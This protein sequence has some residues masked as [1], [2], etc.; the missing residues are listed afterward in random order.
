MN[1]CEYDNNVLCYSFHKINIRALSLLLLL[2]SFG[3]YLCT[4]MYM[5]EE[6]RLRKRTM[7]ICDCI[8]RGVVRGGNVENIFWETR[9][10]QTRCCCRRWR[11]RRRLTFCA[12]T[13]MGVR[14]VQRF[15]R[16]GDRTVLDVIYYDAH[17]A[18]SSRIFGPIVMTPVC[19]GWN[20]TEGHFMSNGLENLSI[21]A[22]ARPDR[23]HAIHFSY[24]IN[25]R[26]QH[27]AIHHHLSPSSTH[28][29]YWAAIRTRHHQF[30]DFSLRVFGSGAHTHTHHALQTAERTEINIP[31][32]RFVALHSKCQT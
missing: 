13:N 26:T 31:C 27:I 28:H 8:R 14:C 7:E 20:L 10:W 25:T 5:L 23:A 32:I 18:H 1:E 19:S 21:W 2:L 9:K 16:K 4:T 11:R 6:K 12:W 24:Q 17:C 29:W 22:H 3:K 15:E 30:W